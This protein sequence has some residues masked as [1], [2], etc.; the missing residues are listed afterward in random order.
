[1]EHLARKAIPSMPELANWTPL[2]FIVD[3]FLVRTAYY[4]P[5]HYD[6]APAMLFNE[7]QDLPGNVHI[8]PDIAGGHVPVAHLPHLCIFRG[9]DTDGDLGRPAEVRPV[10]RN[11]HD[12]PA[13]HATLGFPL[14]PLKKSRVRRSHL[15]SLLSISRESFASAWPTHGRLVSITC[16]N[17][18][19]H[20]GTFRVFRVA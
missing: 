10:E 20:P 19:V 3:A 2:A 13:S 1:M 11:C 14:Q 12:R 4:A 6:R 5:G 9:H 15:R 7:I 16:V 17:L 18:S 8:L